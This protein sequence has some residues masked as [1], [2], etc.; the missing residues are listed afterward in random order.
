M[1]PWMQLHTHTGET[2]FLDARQ[3]QE[4]TDV[5]LL[6][7]KANLPWAKSNAK[8]IAPWSQSSKE[9]WKSRRSTASLS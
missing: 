9:R 5:H 4:G 8:Q 2:S 3:W 7:W 6:K 1:I